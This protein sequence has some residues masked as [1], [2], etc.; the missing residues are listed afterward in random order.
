[1]ETK[2]TENS[3]EEIQQYKTADIKPATSNEEPQT[4]NLP[5]GQASDKL[6]TERMEL[7]HHPH[8]EKK[9]FREYILEGLMIFLA[10]T[11]GFFAESIRERITDNAKEKE[12]I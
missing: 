11:M 5:A 7:H 6:Q 2:E 10:V 4:I 9:N 8:V 1:M 3:P 12:Y